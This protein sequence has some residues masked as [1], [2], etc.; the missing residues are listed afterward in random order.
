M[1]VLLVA[2]AGGHLAELHHLLGRLPG[3]EDRTWVTYD[4]PQSRKLLEGEEVEN[5]FYPRPRDLLATAR[6]VSVARVLLARRQIDAVYSTGASIALSFLPLAVLRGIPATYIES[7]TRLTGPSTTGRLLRTVPGVRLFT[8]DESWAG[9]RWRSAGSVFDSYRAIPDP[10]AEVRRVLVTV[11]GSSYGFRRMIDRMAAV[12][13]STTQ[14]TWQ[15][16]PTVVPARM[17]N[18]RPS[19]P[20][21]ELTDAM[22]TSDVV[23]CHAGIGSALDILDAG[24]CPVLVP[25]LRAHGEHIDDHQVEIAEALADRGLAVVARHGIVTEEHLEQAA[26]TRIIRDL[27][28]L[29]PAL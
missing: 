22:R 9:G 24:R 18:V 7:A 25:R 11:G 8:Q 17:A 28:H 19:L 1:T 27:D 20:W 2:A 21:T 6:N 14:V 5:V 23:V 26:R 16:G 3:A 15:T 12:L 13:P 10:T 4:T 29:A